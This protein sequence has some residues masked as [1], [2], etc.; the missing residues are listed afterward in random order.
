MFKRKNRGPIPA[1]FVFFLFASCM[2]L[3]AMGCGKK[4]SQELYHRFPEGAW[5]RF[6]LLSF[7]IPVKSAGNYNIYLFAGFDPRFEHETL[8]FNMI[9]NTPS[10]EE[11]IH[12]YQ[13]EV[14]SKSGVMSLEC[15][16]DSCLGNIL[17]KRE[18]LIGKPGI[19]IIEIENL[20]PHL[21]TE[22]IKG[23]GIRLVPSGE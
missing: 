21:I 7:K 11:R 1:H 2:L 20:N 9:M 17:L 13:M 8:D 12:E 4:K 5:A 10:G 18:L 23:V 3:V 19:L 6:N 15:S 22:G 16:K 14:R